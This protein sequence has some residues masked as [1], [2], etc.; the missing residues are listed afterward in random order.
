MNDIQPI[1][2]VYNVSYGTYTSQQHKVTK[3]SLPF[4]SFLAVCFGRPW[5][6]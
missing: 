1:S 4:P 2:Q 3:T 5:E 6:S